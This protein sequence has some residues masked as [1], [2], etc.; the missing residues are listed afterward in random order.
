MNSDG[1][2]SDIIFCSK[3]DILS[4]VVI[5]HVTCSGRVSKAKVIKNFN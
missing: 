1:F 3:T 4:K 2:I 5:G